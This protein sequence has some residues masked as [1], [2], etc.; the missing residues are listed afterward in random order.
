MAIFLAIALWENPHL[1]TNRRKITNLLSFIIPLAMMLSLYL[2]LNWMR[3]GHPLEPGYTYIYVAPNVP[4]FLAA[5]VEKYGL[6]HP[7]YIPFNFINL[8]LQGF[9]VEFKG[10][11]YLDDPYMNRFGT[12]LTFASPFIFI[13][14]WATWKRRLLWA[15]WIPIGLALIHILMYHANGWKQINAQRYALDFLPLLTL[16]VALGLKRVPQQ[17]WKAIIIYAVSPKHHRPLFYSPVRIASI[18]TSPPH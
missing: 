8:F 12:S 16:L 7:I 2:W 6:F 1:N 14:F 9:H 13:A 17:L 5:R 3:F 15:A 10:A 4:D 11:T 18:A